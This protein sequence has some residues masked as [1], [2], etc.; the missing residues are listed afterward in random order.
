MPTARHENKKNNPAMPIR[1]TAG[2][3]GQQ[4]SCLMIFYF[5]QPQMALI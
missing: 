4:A 1:E 5:N 3:A 2:G